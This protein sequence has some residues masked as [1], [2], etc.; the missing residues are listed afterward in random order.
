MTGDANYV[1][2]D[3]GDFLLLLS[4]VF[5]LV[6]VLFEVWRERSCSHYLGW[7]A[8]LLLWECT[9]ERTG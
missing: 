7:M 9:T 8:R 6:G 4:F 2:I 1:S 3:V 5:W